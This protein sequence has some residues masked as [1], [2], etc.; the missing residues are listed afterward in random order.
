MYFDLNELDPGRAYKLLAC[1]IVPRPIAWV[2][3]QDENG[4][5]NAAPFSFF[6]AF[7][8]HPPIV[9]IG[10]GHRDMQ[11]KDS[12]N[13]IRKSG[14]FV[15][16]L[17]SEDVLEAMNVTAI[18]FPPDVDEISAAGLTTQPSVVV[19]PPRIVES[20][21]AWECQVQQIIDLDG[22]NSLIIARVVSAHIRDDAVTNKERCYID[23]A[24]LNLVGRMESPGYYVRTT[25]R[26]LM[27][28]IPLEEWK[29][30]SRS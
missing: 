6:N 7:S 13:N 28:Q 19:G 8:G 1:T 27:R 10:M 21:V 5:P 9:C 17:I 3:T 30:S 12:L 16:N 25:D 20:P 2:V 4:R 23:T 15:I 24:S 18:P 29:R 14:D 11:P 22:P 26:F